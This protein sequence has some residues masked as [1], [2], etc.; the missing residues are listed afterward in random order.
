MK[1]MLVVATL[2]AVSACSKPAP[3]PDAEPS[4]AA[5]ATA[6]AAA[7]MAA[8]G[9][10]PVGTFKVTAPDGKVYTEVVKADGTY[11]S[12][13]DGK[14]NETGKWEQK[15]P[16]VYCYTKDAPDAAQK[17]N[18]EK[19]ENGVWTSKGPDGKVATVE[20]VAG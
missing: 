1:K 10:S 14:V 15:S 18:D 13:L 6:P 9:Q 19:V 8:D 12:S 17:C 16:N 4:A 3:A 7:V 20:R 11:E 2:V 5:A